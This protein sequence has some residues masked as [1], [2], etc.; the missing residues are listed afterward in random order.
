MLPQRDDILWCCR[1]A[2][3][4]VA[5]LR[6]AARCGLAVRVTA[7]S[8]DRAQGMH[9]AVTAAWPPREITLPWRERDGK[10]QTHQLIFWSAYGNAVNRNAYNGSWRKAAAAAG[11]RLGA[12]AA[13]TS[14]GTP[15]RAR[16]SPAG[17][18]SVP[19]PNTSGTVIPAS[20]CASIAIFSAAPMTV[21]ALS[22]TLP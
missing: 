20:P 19:W 17:W 22:L 10:P 15:M 6:R 4:R 12:T 16:C 3:F 2:G 1:C 13:I 18:I 8:L 5:Q 9:P 7:G 14:C 11:C 21:R